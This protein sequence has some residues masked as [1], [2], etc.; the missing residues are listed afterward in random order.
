M[1][2]IRYF[3]ENIDDVNLENYKDDIDKIFENDKWLVIKPKSFES[4]LYWSQDTD[5]RIENVNVKYHPSVGLSPQT[6]KMNDSI[7]ININK[8][9]DEKY[10]FDFEKED[11]YDADENDIYLY[12]FLD[13]N[14]ELFNVYGEIIDVYNVVKENDSYWMVVPDNNYFEKFFNLDRN[15]RNDL[16]KSVLSGDSFDIFSYNPRD[17]DI[18][19][20][21]IDLSEKNLDLLKSVL[22]LEKMYNED[23]YDYEVEDIKDYDD[24]AYIV[25]EYDIEEFKNIL[26]QIICQATESA[27]GDAAYDDILDHV[28]K[29]FNFVD[30]SANWKKYK[31]NKYDYL[32]IKFKTNEDAYK[33]KFILANYDDSFSDDKIDY[34]PPY[35]GYSADS[36]NFKDIVNEYLPDK[37]S[38]YDSDNVSGDD[39]FDIYEYIIKYKEKNPNFTDKELLSEIDVYINSKKYNL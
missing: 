2:Y 4:L 8:Q 19:D 37:I 6:Y 16:I 1:K 21:N 5:W 12:D 30:G 32:W 39:I 23:D 26:Q 31:D 15:T 11:F 29:F 14:K 3:E 25:S 17:F 13:D 28:Y 18:N 27:E 10:L 24:V 34:S 22:I 38:D 33:A 20:A 7:Y 36:K 35:Y 9:K